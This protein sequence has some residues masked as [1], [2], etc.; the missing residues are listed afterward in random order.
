MIYTLHP[1]SYTPNPT[2]CILHPISYTLYPT[3]YTLNPEP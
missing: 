3:P 1:I 2:P